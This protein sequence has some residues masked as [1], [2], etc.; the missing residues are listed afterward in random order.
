MCRCE[1]LIRGTPKAELHMHLEGAV[2]P[3]LLIALASRNRVSLPWRTA[4]EARAAYRF[5]SLQDFL[6]LF[7]QGLR[8]LVTE[9]DFRQVTLAYLEAARRDNVVHAE[10]FVSP[11]G[12]LRRGVSFETMMEG[13][14][15]ALDEGRGRLGMSCGLILLFQ[16][17]LSEED[18]FDVLERARP[19]RERIVGFGMGGAE[20]PNP[21]AK[22][23]RVY[24]AC[25][26]EG[27]RV[28]A[29]AGEEGGPCFVAEALDE[30]EI[31]RIDHGVRAAEDEA[32]LARIVRK[33]IPMTVCPVS[34]VKLGVFADMASHTIKKLMAAGALV[35]INSDDPA[36]F[37]AGL[38]DNYL[39]VHAALGL[40]EDEIRQLALNSFEAA[41][42]PE[43]EKK[44][45]RAA[46][47]EFFAR[48]V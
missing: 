27:Y 44:R 5:T 42:L 45:H 7:Y 33:R 32:L 38:N 15:G 31:E 1:R 25:R 43:D 35:T 21:P 46:I 19:W 30:L 9:Q 13:V 40:T 10:I 16:R 39:A 26:A 6:D 37:G 3:E 11:Q 18:A 36:Y 28:V 8:V 4:E 23:A 48:A 47:E 41:F 29:H 14:L 20:L 12:H 34:N 17:H 24:A 22:F 2:E